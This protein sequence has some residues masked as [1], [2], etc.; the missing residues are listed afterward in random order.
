[1]TTYLYVEGVEY[2]RDGGVCLRTPGRQVEGAPAKGAGE[3]R[4]RTLRQETHDLE[5]GLKARLSNRGMFEMKIPMRI[6]Y[7]SSPLP[8]QK[9]N[10]LGSPNTQRSCSGHAII[11]AKMI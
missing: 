9:R 6:P 11:D 4:I 2:V 3:G 7:S 5:D 1:M 10:S 8:P